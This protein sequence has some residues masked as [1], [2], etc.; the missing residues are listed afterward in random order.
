[1][2]SVMAPQAYYLA[3][4]MWKAL[5]TVTCR[6]MIE[7]VAAAVVLGAELLIKRPRNIVGTQSE[8]GDQQM[9]DIVG[10]QSEYGD[11]Q[12][13]ASSVGFNIPSL[14]VPH[15]PRTAGMKRNDCVVKQE[16]YS[17]SDPRVTH[18]FVGNLSSRVRQPEYLVA[19]S[20]GTT[21]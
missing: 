20:P 19:G 1:M 10:T 2:S 17:C 3:R 18:F 5:T 4:C 13:I 15:T 6:K 11:Q 14:I 8:Y 12:M 7:R 16:P 9:I 21:S